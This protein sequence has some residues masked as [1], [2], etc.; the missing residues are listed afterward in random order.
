MTIEQRGVID[1][2]STDEGT[3]NIRLT[4][5]DHLDWNDPK[6]DHLLILQDKIND[7]L[8]FIEGGQLYEEYPSAKGKK[9]I[10]QVTAKYPLGK[11]AEHFY[12][13]A[14]EAV[15][16]AGFELVFKLLQEQ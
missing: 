7:Y 11:E 10:I 6:N 12:H 8:A 16:N 15:S 4:I 14:S 2:V 3:G 1:F 13:H 9:I 5:S